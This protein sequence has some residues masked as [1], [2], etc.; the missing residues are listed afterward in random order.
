MD[1]LSRA[2]EWN[3]VPLQGEK[4][5]KPAFIRRQIQEM[6]IGTFRNIATVPQTATL[7]DAL[8]I[9]VD[10]RVSALP[11]VDEKGMLFWGEE[12]VGS[13]FEVI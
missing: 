1:D 4:V 12:V 7:F 5:P 3:C 9:F 11:V 2:I 6:G 13:V 8:D 10:R